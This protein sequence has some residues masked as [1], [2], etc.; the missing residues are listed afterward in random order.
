MVDVLEMNAGEEVEL[1][2]T[3]SEEGTKYV[4]ESVLSYPRVLEKDQRGGS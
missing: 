3:R 4:G 1:I 2:W